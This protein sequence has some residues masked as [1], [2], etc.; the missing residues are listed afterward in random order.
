MRLA[1]NVENEEHLAKV[2]RSGNAHEDMGAP[3]AL[4]K[5]H[6]KVQA[7]AKGKGKGKKRTPETCLCRGKEGHKKADRKFKTA[8]CSNCG[9]IGHLR[10]VC[11][12]T[13]TYEIEK[14][15]DEPRRSLVHGWLFKPLSMM[16]TVIAMRNVT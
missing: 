5:V 9:K 16:V 15:V 8:T 13:N 10:E 7:R 4:A 6:V 1:R 3:R 12:N 14:D 11:R 2:R